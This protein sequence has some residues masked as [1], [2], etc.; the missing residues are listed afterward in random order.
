MPKPMFPILLGCTLLRR[1]E[2][3]PVI[4]KVEHQPL[5]AQV[6][7]V[8]EALEM[9]GEP[10]PAAETAE[11]RQLIASPKDPRQAV[12]RI[13]AILDRHCLV[14]VEI[15]PESRVKAQQGPA[16]AELVQQGWRTF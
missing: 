9:L 2:Q 1:A 13:Q 14:G 12:A 7:R 10:F 5:A 3:L 16:S 4:E 11:L 8:I 6:S 15:N